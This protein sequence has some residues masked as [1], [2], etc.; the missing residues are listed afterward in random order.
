MSVM[1]LVLHCIIALYICMVLTMTNLTNDNDYN[2]DLVSDA[3][4][5]LYPDN[6]V[7]ADL[8]TA[9]A[10]LEG[11]L[12]P[13]KQPSEL[14]LKYNNLFGIKGHGTAG[15]VVLPSPEYR[16]SNGKW[17]TDNSNFAVNKNIEDSLEQHKELFENGTSDNPDRY[18]KVLEA[19]TFEEA[20]YAVQKA[21]YAT[22][23]GY[24]NELISVY[25]EYIK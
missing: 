7:L 9:Q 1:K 5:K 21:G 6:P 14:A 20:A 19:K 17:E 16:G 11:R 25:N 8:T 13:G 22:D 10:I 18:D 12:Q 24:A 3:A 2:I 15:S 4:H 23:P